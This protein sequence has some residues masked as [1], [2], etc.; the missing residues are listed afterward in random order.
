MSGRSAAAQLDMVTP[1]TGA[2]QGPAP[3]RVS[4]MSAQR[5]R[6]RRRYQFNVYALRILTAVIVLSAW[7]LST[8]YAPTVIDPFFWG[9]PSG[10]WHQLVVWVTDETALGPLWK[11]VLVTMEETV[12]RL[13]REPNLTLARTR[14]A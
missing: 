3:A 9:Q 12:E 5:I 4:D 13:S 7:E 11:Q 10:I 14:T 8:R 6:A 1:E 2:P